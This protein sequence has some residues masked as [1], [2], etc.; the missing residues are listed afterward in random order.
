MMDRRDISKRERVM[1]ALVGN[2]M[3]FSL[4]YEDSS[5][6]QDV[7]CVVRNGSVLERMRSSILFALHIYWQRDESSEKLLDSIIWDYLTI[8]HPDA[9]SRVETLFVS[10]LIYSLME[11]DEPMAEDIRS[12]I[13]A[14]LSAAVACVSNDDK[15]RKELDDL[16]EVIY[17]AVLISENGDDNTDSIALLLENVVDG[18]SGLAIDADSV[19]VA[20]AVYCILRHYDNI[21][22]AFAAAMSYSTRLNALAAILVF[23]IMGAARGVKALPPQSREMVESEPMIQEFMEYVCQIDI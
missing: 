12:H 3:S 20:V 19:A 8:E 23:N 9:Q 18:S 15:S 10:H 5:V 14:A 7:R 11:D 6:P 4:G 2:Y 22:R 21:D 17:S 1:G 16:A 13:G